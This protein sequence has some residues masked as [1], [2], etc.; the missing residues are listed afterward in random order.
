MGTK[1]T[2]T[3]VGRITVDGRL[4]VAPDVRSKHGSVGLRPDENDKVLSLIER[5]RK[6]AYGELLTR[7]SYRLRAKQLRDILD[8]LVARGLVSRSKEGRRVLYEF[9]GRIDSSLKEA[10]AAN[11]LELPP[12]SEENASPA[13]DGLV[14]LS[15]VLSE[16]DLNMQL[17]GP[18]FVGEAKLWAYRNTCVLVSRGP[19][20]DNK[21]VLLIVKKAVL[22]D[23]AERA[24]FQGEVERLEKRASGRY[25]C[26]GESEGIRLRRESKVYSHVRKR[27]L[28]ETPEEIVRQETVCALVNEYGYSL[29]QIAEEA[30]V[31][32]SGS[33]QARADLLVWR[34]ALDNLEQRSP[35][36]VVECK[37]GNDPI[38][39]DECQQGE[40]YARLSGAKFLV[41]RNNREMRCWRVIHDKMPKSLEEVGDIP[42]ACVAGQ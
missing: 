9:L 32:G 5:K 19:L 27:W 39:P 34:S 3:I 35:L 29:D 40:N 16:R 14:P 17:E 36:I 10:G 7:L 22:E 30:V 4:W 26:Q 11:T 23:E 42:R 13:E 28:T 20:D 24:S 8:E 38:Q 21:H 33:A 37:A 1:A 18:V 6:I 15:V 12:S 25:E 31:T 2:A 41:V